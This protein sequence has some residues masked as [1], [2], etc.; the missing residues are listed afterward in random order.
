MV[1]RDSNGRFAHDPNSQPKITKPKRTVS[2]QDKTGRWHNPKGKFTSKKELKLEQEQHK[3]RTDRATKEQMAFRSSEISTKQ[4][5]RYKVIVKMHTNQGL[6]PGY[7]YSRIPRLTD[8]D[9][10]YL[11]NLLQDKY[12]HQYKELRVYSLEYITAYDQHTGKRV[13]YQ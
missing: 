4:V 6:H 5:Y 10:E 12:R 3:K 7:I 11:T 1:Y 2:F 9:K 8:R 13:K